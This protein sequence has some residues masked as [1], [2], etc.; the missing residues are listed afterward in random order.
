[1]CQ[2]QDV[3][4]SFACMDSFINFFSNNVFQEKF[5]KYLLLDSPIDDVKPKLSYSNH[6]YI[7]QECKQNWYLECSPTEETYPVFGIK[8][9]Y[10]LTENEIN[11][12]KQFLV[13]LAH[14][15]FSPDPCAYHGCLNFALKNIKICVK[16]YSY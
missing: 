5:P 14:D 13:I 2:C 9:I 11:A 6:Y 7:C 8:T 3:E 4:D 12:A 10:A 16:H 15:G 1:M